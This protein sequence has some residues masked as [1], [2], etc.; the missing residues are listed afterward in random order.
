MFF[1]GHSTP[2]N[3]RYLD[4]KQVLW[5]IITLCHAWEQKHRIKSSID[6]VWLRISKSQDCI[7]HNDCPFYPEESCSRNL[8][9]VCQLCEWLKWNGEF[10]ANSNGRT[11]SWTLYMVNSLKWSL[12][13]IRA[14]PKS[15]STKI[16]KCE[17][18]PQGKY[19]C[20]E[21]EWFLPNVWTMMQN[22]TVLLM[23]TDL[24]PASWYW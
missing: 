21:L 14:T 17:Q 18:F 2:D 8:Y 4:L 9:C 13:E 19:S 7:H 22:H 3:I 24:T 16:L 15:S 6:D 11:F 23:P 5:V 10:S 20:S 1:L 12:W